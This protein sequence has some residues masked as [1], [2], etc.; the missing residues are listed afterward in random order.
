MKLTKFIKKLQLTKII[1]TFLL[2]A[3][4]LVTTACNSG[5][6]VG[7]RPNNR[8]VQ[9]GGQ[10]NPHK[11]GGDG[12]TQYKVTNDP[13]VIKKGKDN[14]SLPDSTLLAAAN[15][16][17]TSYP[18]NDS[19][20]EGLLYSD[21]EAESLNNVNDVV[22]PARQRQLLDP[23]QIPAQ[24]QTAID[25]SDPDNKLLEKTG[26]MFDDAANFSPN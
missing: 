17:E 9:L 2:A 12:M 1:S 26:Q 13:R 3:I 25:R 21:D 7:A 8:P 11:A 6:E 5:N 24:K 14:A 10:N 15:R 18:T 19:K 22:S 4:V 16:S 20:V 23:T